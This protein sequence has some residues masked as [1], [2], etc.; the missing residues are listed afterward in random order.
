MHGKYH[1]K[2]AAGLLAVS[3][4]FLL[5]G[6]RASSAEDTDSVLKINEQDVVKA[7]Y[8][9]VLNRYKAQVKSLYTTDDINKED[10]WTTEF[11][12]G[13]PLKKIMRLAEEELIRKKVVAEMAAQ[14]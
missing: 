3:C 2:I 14:Y 1:K 12:E 5:M 7:E 8:Q 9:M 6:C 10:F 11:E 4:A 13:I